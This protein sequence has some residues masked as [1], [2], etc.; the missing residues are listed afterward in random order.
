M[1]CCR[2]CIYG[3]RALDCWMIWRITFDASTQQYRVV[4]MS[5]RRFYRD[6]GD[7]MGFKMLAVRG[8]KAF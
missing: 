4:S 1:E 6:G 8:I 7:G 2:G 3:V 5:R